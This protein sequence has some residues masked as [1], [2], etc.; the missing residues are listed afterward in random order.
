MTK[1]QDNDLSTPHQHDNNWMFLRFADVLLIYAEA[2]NKQNN[3]STP[4]ALA[5]INRVRDRA[6]LADLTGPYSYD[7]FLQIIQ[8]ERF[9]EL[10]GEGHRLVDLRRWGFNTLK[11]RVEMSHPSATVEPHEILWPFPSAELRVNP[12]I[13]QNDGY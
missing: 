9:K 1:F 6:G 8:D 7:Q 4:E 13:E 11:Q 12:L 2:L 5:A 10:A 3:G